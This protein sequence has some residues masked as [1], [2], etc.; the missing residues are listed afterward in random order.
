MSAD[1]DAEA[2]S[3]R[4]R[5]LAME[6]NRLATQVVAK[7]EF[8]SNSRR[9]DSAGR[10]REVW[11]HAAAELYDARQKRQKFFPEWMFGEPAWDMLID[12]FMAE[13]KNQLV[14]VTS[15]CLASNVP[16][17]TALRSLRQLE[18]EGFVIR[19]PDPE[20]SRRSNVY[21]TD[22]AHNQVVDYFAIVMSHLAKEDFLTPEKR[23][24]DSYLIKG[25]E[26][27]DQEHEAD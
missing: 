27:V 23:D 21:L 2:M 18:A 9:T 25:E 22:H 6:A 1:N 7:G 26:R 24:T 15:A 3:R 14:S 19:E 16:P 5:L 12:L 13:K 4:L 8:V 17:T 11:L 20:D 10:S